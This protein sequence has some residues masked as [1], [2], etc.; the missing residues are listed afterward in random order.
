M[1]I[2][3]LVSL[4]LVFSNYVSQR[5]F[6]YSRDTWTTFNNRVTYH[7]EYKDYIKD[8]YSEQLRAAQSNVSWVKTRETLDKTWFGACYGFGVTSML[9]NAELLNPETI[10]D[11]SAFWNA[12]SASVLDGMSEQEIDYCMDHQNL[13]SIMPMY[14]SSGKMASYLMYYMWLQNKESVCQEFARQAYE[15]TSQEQLNT[16][17]QLTPEEP[18]LIGLCK[19]DSGR[20][21]CHAIVG[22][23]VESGSWEWNGIEYDTRIL[24][25][26]SNCPTT[27]TAAMDGII[28]SRNRYNLYLQSDNPAIWCKPD[29]NITQDNGAIKAVVNDLSLLNDGGLVD[30]TPAYHAPEQ[31]YDVIGMNAI[32]Q[33]PTIQRVDRSHDYVPYETD[34]SD[35]YF[36][37]FTT[38]ILEYEGMDSAYYLPNDD[39]AYLVS[40]E[41]P[42]VLKPRLIGKTS[43]IYAESTCASQVLLDENGMAEITGSTAPFNYEMVF[44][45]GYYN[46]SW[47]QIAVSGTAGCTSLS[48]TENGYLFSS[49]TTGRICITASNDTETVSVFVAA[50]DRPMQIEE[51]NGVL[52]AA[53]LPYI[54]VE[55]LGDLDDSGEANAA[56][57]SAI[58]VAAAGAGL[59]G[60]DG[61][62]D[63]QRI[64]ADVDGDGEISAVD[65]SLVLC[66]AAETGLGT[67]SGVLKDFLDLQMEKETNSF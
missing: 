8:E 45:E 21:V 34:A 29:L 13:I 3:G 22:Y 19:Y 32:E 28:Q 56:D 37:E 39:S 20:A 1:F 43:M 31:F 61:L 67:F 17:L 24:V 66:Y 65:A 52:T 14:A 62:T 55:S 5:A 15:K 44:N 23:G 7:D 64:A 50:N 54:L 35:P 2:L 59:T 6:E 30:G 36:E 42:S 53:G 60:E 46:G 16:L 58:L 4:S 18:A 51:K 10:A 48:Q 63:T 12:D 27:F 33:L 40:I 26:D 38:Y 49:D 11:S 57:A 47:Y 9:A 25:Y 41:D